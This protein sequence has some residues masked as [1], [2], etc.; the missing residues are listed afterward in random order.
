MSIKK[1]SSSGRKSYDY[2]LM[3]LAN[4]MDEGITI[5][6]T[7]RLIKEIPKDIHGMLSRYFEIETV[8]R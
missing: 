5:L 6:P 2:T 3:F 1:T 4:L 8:A 7:H